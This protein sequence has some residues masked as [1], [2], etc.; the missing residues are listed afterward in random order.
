MLPQLHSDPVRKVLTVFDQLL[1]D[2][3]ADFIEADGAVYHY[4]VN[5]L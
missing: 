2:R 4:E 1:A 5:P 3:I